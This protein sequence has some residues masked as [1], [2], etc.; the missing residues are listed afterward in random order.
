VPSESSESSDRELLAACRRGDG[1]AWEDL[2]RKYRRLI[3]SIP[4]SCG[5]GSE[6]ADDVFQ[7]VAILLVENVAKIRDAESLPAWIMTTTRRESWALKRQGTRVRAF[8]EGEAESMAEEPP[9]IAAAIDRVGEEH[10]VQL[11]FAKLQEP[12]RSLLSALY[13]EDPTPPYE[14]IAERLGRPIGSLGP[15][16]ARCLAKLR[17]LLGV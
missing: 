4:H 13:V 9:D 6:H 17:K 15:T 5:L 3:Y 2:I 7:R 16:R 1:R 12:C 8:A 10:A 14:E 11:A